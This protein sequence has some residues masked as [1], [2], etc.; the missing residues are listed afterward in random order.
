MMNWNEVA[1]IM[2]VSNG[3]FLLIGFLL[4]QIKFKDNDQQH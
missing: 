1:A 3:A 2:L 4:G